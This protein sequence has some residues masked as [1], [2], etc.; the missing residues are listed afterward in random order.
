MA[1]TPQKRHLF[2]D[3]SDIEPCTAGVHCAIQTLSNVKESPKCVKYYCGIVSDG[4]N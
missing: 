2:E 1:K 4:K 3:L